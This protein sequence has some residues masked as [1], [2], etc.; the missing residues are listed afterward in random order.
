[1]FQVKLKNEMPMRFI[2]IACFLLIC[3]LSKNL[4]A[5]EIIG[6]IGYGSWENGNYSSFGAV[7]PSLEIYVPVYKNFSAGFGLSYTNVEYGSKSELAG[8]VKYLDAAD[9]TGKSEHSIVPLQLSL[10][11]DYEFQK[12][13]KFVG[14]I[15]AGLSAGQD[16]YYHSTTGSDP[17]NMTTDV[18]EIGA[19]KVFGADLGVAYRQILFLLTYSAMNVENSYHQSITEPDMPQTTFQSKNNTTMQ[20]IGF[21]IAYMF[22]F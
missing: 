11:Y 1:M 15:R 12:N 16:T 5:T 8:G 6:G 2:K 7:T 14:I 21:K 10:K 9:L 4:K 20:T 18:L 13:W 3:L 17:T 22:D 19:D